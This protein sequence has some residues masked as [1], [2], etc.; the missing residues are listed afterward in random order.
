MKKLLLL[1]THYS[2]SRWEIR[3]IF[4]NKTTENTERFKKEKI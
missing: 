3:R 1:P 2:F 4:R